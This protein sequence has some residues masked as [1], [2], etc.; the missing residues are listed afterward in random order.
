MVQASGWELVCR[1]CGARTPFGLVEMDR[2]L[3]GLKLLRPEAKPDPDIVVE[4]IK[5][6]QPKLTCPYCSGQG[7]ALESAP[8]E[9]DEDWGMAR[10]CE[11]CGK[12]I[13]AERLEVFPSTRLCLGCQAADEQ[14]ESGDA[15]EYCSRC[16]TPMQLRKS[17]RPGITRYE[18][19][20]PNCR[21]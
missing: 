19:H 21:R 1:R 4:L 2:M 16:G 3:R 8:T 10:A 5:A 20:C 9:S 14:G 17:T 7:L 18:M 13:P 11:S 12:P 15:P 6:A